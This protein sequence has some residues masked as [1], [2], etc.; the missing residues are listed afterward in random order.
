MDNPFDY[1]KEIYCINLDHRVD[2]WEHAQDE[3]RS[4]GILDR[5]KRFSAV[6]HKDGRIG[7]IKSFLQIFKDVKERNIENVLIFE[8]DVHFI[9][10]NKPLETLQKAIEQV[11]AIDW[12]LFYLGANTHEKCTIFRPNLILIR[13]AFSAHAIAYS[14]KTYKT[15]IERFEKTNEIKSINDINDV[16]F[17]N[18]IQNK[19]TSF[20]VNPMIATQFPSFSDLE[21]KHVN[22]SFIEERFKNNT[23]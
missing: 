19:R 8:D 7:L 22:Y 10:E 13:N 6:E 9:L 23:R 1:F 20:L 17:C 14:H 21:K 15:I 16:F 5:V 3:F 4:L 2:R 12:S 18:E 11:G